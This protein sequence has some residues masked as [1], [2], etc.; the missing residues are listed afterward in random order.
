MR[1]V[2]WPKPARPQSRLGRSWSGRATT[3]VSICGS[4]RKRREAD[5]GPKDAVDDIRGV[6]FSLWHG[7]L[8]GAVFVVRPGDVLALDRRGFHDAGTGLVV[9]FAAED[10]IAAAATAAAAVLSRSGVGR[11]GLV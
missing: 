5:L 7:G 4:A 1:W 10:A 11:G 9:G 3:A 6:L 8:D 2:R